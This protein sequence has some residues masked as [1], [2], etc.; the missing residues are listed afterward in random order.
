MRAAWMTAVAALG[1]LLTP[2]VPAGADESPVQTIG[3]LQ[4]EGYTVNVDRVGNAPLEQCTVI[5]IR[6]P[7]QVTRL[8]RVGDDRRGH[9]GGEL[10]EIVVSQS[11]SVSLDCTR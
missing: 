9:N 11:I 2:T 6:N 1:V 4:A 7:Q 3:R 10:V 8:V 5:G